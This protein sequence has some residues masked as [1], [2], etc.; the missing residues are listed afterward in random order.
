MT[1]LTRQMLIDKLRA[2]AAGTSTALA[3]WAFD[4]FYAEEEGALSFEPGYQRVIGSV[5]DD[6]MFSDQSGF[7]LS[8]S[9]LMQLSDFLAQATP[10]A[11]DLDEDEDEDDRDDAELE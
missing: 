9:E 5:L 2:A 4:Q 10:T 6:L 7:Q 11:D 1:T 8:A 3:A